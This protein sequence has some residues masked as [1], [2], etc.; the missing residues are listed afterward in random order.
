MGGAGVVL[1]AAPMGRSF[2]GGGC[3]F[4]FW[5]GRWLFCQGFS[6]ARW[7]AGVGDTESWFY[8]ALGLSHVLDSRPAC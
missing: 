4:S 8:L 3:G 6:G 5:G 1:S 7:G 2:L